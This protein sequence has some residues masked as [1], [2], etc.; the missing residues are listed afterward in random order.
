MDEWCVFMSSG[1]YPGGERRP[2]GASLGPQSGG[3]SVYTVVQ[4]VLTAAFCPTRDAAPMSDAL[5]C[6]LKVAQEEK[7]IGSLKSNG[8]IFTAT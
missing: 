5:T 6:F 3:G 2:L 8:F 7:V 4:S 1:V